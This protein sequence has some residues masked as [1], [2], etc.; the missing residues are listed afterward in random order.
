MWEKLEVSKKFKTL[1]IIAGIKSI[2]PYEKII[3]S[4]SLDIK[5]SGQFFDRTEVFS[6]LSKTRKCF[7]FQISFYLWNA[8]KMTNLSDMNSLIMRRMLFYC[9]KLLKIDF[10]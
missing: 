4:D 6:I 7:K 8:L 2:F 10:N 3:F 1:E 5:P 9:V